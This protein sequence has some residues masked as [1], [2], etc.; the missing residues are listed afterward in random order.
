MFQAVAGTGDESGRVVFEV[1]TGDAQAAR[2]V[3]FASRPSLQVSLED[4]NGQFTSLAQVDEVLTAEHE[5]LFTLRLMRG[6]PPSSTER[7]ALVSGT[8]LLI[9]AAAGLGVEL[10]QTDLAMPSPLVVL[11]PLCI[12]R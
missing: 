9:E 1:Y 4:V 7:E 8:E 11:R 12:W 3:A 6:A 10:A 5:E 2:V